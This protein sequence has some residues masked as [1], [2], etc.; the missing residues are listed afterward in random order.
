MTHKVGVHMNAASQ[1]NVFIDGVE[2]TNAKKI[3]IIAEVGQPTSVRLTLV[4]CDVTV[5]ADA[6]VIDKTEEVEIN[7]ASPK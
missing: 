4:N 3:E 6:D 7:R 1:G 2:V 5:R